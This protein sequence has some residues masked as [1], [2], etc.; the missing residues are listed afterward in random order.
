[1][2][3]TLTAYDRNDPDS[4]EH[5]LL[6]SGVWIPSNQVTLRHRIRTFRGRLERSGTVARVIARHTR[7]ADLAGHTFTTYTATAVGA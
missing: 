2:A 5:T 4:P 7:K 3:Y 1:M 6:V